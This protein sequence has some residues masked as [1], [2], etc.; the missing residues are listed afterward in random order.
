MLPDAGNHLSDVD[1]GALT[2]TL[3]HDEGAVVPVQGAHTDL[4]PCGQMIVTAFKQ[5]WP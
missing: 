3:T 5:E 2:T 4:Q 1:G